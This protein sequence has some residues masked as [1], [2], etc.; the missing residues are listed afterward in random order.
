MTIKEVASLAGVSSAAVSRY[1]NGGSLS[2]EKREKIRRA[3]KETG[4]RPNLMARSMRTG[5]GGQVGV[6]VPKVRSDSVSNVLMG[7]SEILSEAGYL[8]LL[9]NSETRTDRE[10]SYLEVM[11]NNQVAGIILMGTIMT[12]ESLEAVRSAKVPVVVTGQNLDG[13]PCV[14]HDDFHAA[15]D[16][17]ALLTEK[18]RRRIVYIGADEKD[19][20][21]GLERRRGVQEALR[22]AGLQAES[23]PRRI[24]PFDPAGGYACMRELLEEV[25]DL[26]GVVCATD[27]IAMGA[28][29]ALAESGRSVPGDVSLVGIGDSWAVR[30]CLPG[31]TIARLR[32]H[33]CGRKAAGLLLDLVRG[34]AV[35]SVMLPYSITDRGSV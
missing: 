10:Q 14:Y 31:I 20:A 8:T 32:F 3:I 1:I 18:G 27:N 21:A 11:Q 16:V 35:R 17:T 6:I 22:A 2:A 26:D 24:S 15:R 29:K 33:D 5:R 25:P 9:G 12:P 13:I 34:E 7:I 23:L 4:Y 28:L 19:L 30:F